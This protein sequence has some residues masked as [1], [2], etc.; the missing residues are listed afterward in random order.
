MEKKAE[1]MEKWYSWD[2]LFIPFFLF[3]RNKNL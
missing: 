3:R 2:R 1:K